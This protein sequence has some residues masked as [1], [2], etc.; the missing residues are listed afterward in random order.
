MLARVVEEGGWSRRVAWSKRKV[1]QPG[2]SWP[3]IIVGSWP[4]DSV[5]KKEVVYIYIL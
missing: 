5:K 2:V 3:H 1:S 4:N